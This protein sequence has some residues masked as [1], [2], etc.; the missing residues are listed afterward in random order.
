MGTTTTTVVLPTAATVSFSMK[1]GGIT[2]SKS[3]INPF[4]TS[5]SSTGGGGGGRLTNKSNGGNNAN[6]GRGGQG[7]GLI[8]SSGSFKRLHS[9]S[10][11]SLPDET[12]YARKTI[13]AGKQ[14][15]SVEK[16]WENMR[17][18]F[19]SNELSSS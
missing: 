2:R 16:L 11:I 12:T 13:D 5:S 18:I 19:S 14:Y 9:N 3:M 6:K 10:Y 7:L 4:P 17:W 1:H 8:K 15:N